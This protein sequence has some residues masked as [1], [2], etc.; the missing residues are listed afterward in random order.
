[1]WDQSGQ[2]TD[3]FI[4][5]CFSKHYLFSLTAAVKRGTKKDEISIYLSISFSISKFR[6][7]SGLLCI[8]GG[9]FD[10]SVAQNEGS[11]EQTRQ[12]V[13]MGARWFKNG[14]SNMT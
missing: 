1:M 12:S 13:M 8:G 5:D 7:E 11:C 4:L 9:V 3:N 6:F 2:A 14:Y 10:L